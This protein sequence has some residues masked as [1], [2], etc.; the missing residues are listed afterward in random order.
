LDK[1]SCPTMTDHS[2]ATHH[3]R[4]A[5]DHNVDPAE[6]AKFEAAATRWWD[7]SSE[8]GA[9]HAINPLRL[10]FIER[11]CMLA[12]ARVVDV[13]CGGGLLSE[14]MARAGADVLGID[15]G[16]GP[17][18]VA[19]LHA[20]ESDVA[21]RYERRSAESLAA[22][23]PGAFD[24]VTCMEMLEHVPE[25]ASVV[26]ACARLAKPGGVVVCSTINRNLMS[27]L[28][29]IVVAEQVL[30]LL[31]KGTHDHAHF[32]RPSELCGWARRAGLRLI[33]LEGMS[34]D[35][36]GRR[37]FMTR[38]VEVNYLAAFS[39]PGEDGQ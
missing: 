36:L 10:E 1:E 39:R 5:L 25:P 18:Q 8:F 2:A 20:L 17:L 24:L 19:R 28:Q 13:G 22:E 34:Y 4:P 27:W 38:S 3:D 11:H 33:A 15:M 29:A 26:E 31:P 21:V 35:P 7:P 32:I 6:L 16:K 37:Y 23:Q 9:L 14:S 12:G 30:G